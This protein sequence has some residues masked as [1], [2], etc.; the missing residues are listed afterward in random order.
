MSFSK[1]LPSR[2]VPMGPLAGLHTMVPSSL[3][4]VWW[5]WWNAVNNTLQEIGLAP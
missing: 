2:C 5:G 3:Q 1:E 4:A